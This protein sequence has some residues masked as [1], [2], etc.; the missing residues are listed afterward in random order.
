ME[1]YNRDLKEG[2]L[3]N[4]NPYI[5]MGE[6]GMGGGRYHPV[7]ILMNLF[8]RTP[9]AM[10]LLL[11]IHV[12]MMGCFMYLYLLEIGAGLRGGIFGAVAYMFNGC[13][14]VWLEYESWVM[15]GAYLPLLLLFAERVLGQRKFF[16][17]F[18]GGIVWG[19]SIL[20]GGYQL[21]EY[22]AILMFFY[23]LFIIVRYLR[24]G[25]TWQGMLAILGCFA[26]AGGL[27][28]VI[29]AVDM[30]P[31]NEL[32]S[33]SGR[34]TRVFTFRELFDTLARI[35][36]RYF[37]TLL[38]PDFFGSP[39]LHIT[40]IP[41]LPTH[42][43][44]NYNELNMYMGV[45]TVFAF[46][47]CLAAPPTAFSRFYIFMTIILAAM[48]CGTFVYYP[49][50]KLVPGMDKMN[51]TRL[52]FLFV[53]VFIVS[54]ALGIKGLEEMRRKQR[55]MFAGIGALILLVAAYI[56]FW[57][58]TYGTIAWFN[59]EL[60]R[61]MTGY[62]TYLLDSVARLRSPSSP[63]IYKQLLMV[64]AVFCFFS[65]FI[66]SKNRK[67]KNVVFFLLISLLSYDLISFAANYNTTV[68]PESIYPRTPAIDYL[69]GQKR[70]FRVA[71]DIGHHFYYNTLIPFELEDVG[72][73]RSVYPARTNR[74]LSYVSLGDEMFDGVFFDRWV[75]FNDFS[76]RFFDL[77]NVR[78]VLTS[79]DHR[80]QDPKYK[81]AFQGDIA[82]Y[83]NTQVMPRAYAVH[84][85][86]VRQ[87]PDLML[88]YMGS[89]VFD[90]R[91]EVLLESDPPADFLS[92]T[93]SPA[94][95]PRVVI[96]KYTP[97]E[98]Q[99]SADMSSNGWLVLSDTYYPGW[100][101]TVDGREAGILR[102]N[103][104]FRALELSGGRHNVTFKFR[105]Q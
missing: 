73:Y 29:G 95:P 35:P 23:S 63:V 38:F 94:Y 10:T 49:F 3:N 58:N 12:L 18:G 59:H 54:S 92:G 57:G 52:I 56:A 69:L 93:G 74:F 30:I 19:L 61:T 22:A 102:A 33:N 20:T 97:D 42:E 81:L 105:P 103:F 11:F 51:P 14:M 99:I 39:L 15:V 71:Q 37:V 16:Y 41:T 25:G 28:L 66:F 87:D 70:P 68:R 100:K 40:L 60:F 86:L 9:E 5:L 101:A 21:I 90:M 62:K 67:V 48:V 1:N 98:V 50:F 27:G 64:C 79:P 80:I 96:E 46:A 76:S 91:N 78:Y 2:R 8:F 77:L 89:D 85:H 32:V 31:F 13:A 83:E 43:Y 44:M 34:V 4:W 26:I 84:K 75:G 7:R 88:R 17:A 24:S 65:F 6:P 104:N 47:A 45:A 55:C 53:F 72:G 36:F 82:V